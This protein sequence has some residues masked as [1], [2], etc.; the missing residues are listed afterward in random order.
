MIIAANCVSSDFV[1]FGRIYCLTF[2]LMLCLFNL[3]FR[4]SGKSSHVFDSLSNQSTLRRSLRGMRPPMPQTTQSSTP[5]APSEDF[6][7]VVF[8]FCEEQFPYRTRIPGK[9]VTLKQFKDYL[10]KKGNYRYS[11][12]F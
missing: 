6:T 4:G 12:N 11:F 8:S 3:F 7:I 5:S 2:V 1:C 9:H 10:P